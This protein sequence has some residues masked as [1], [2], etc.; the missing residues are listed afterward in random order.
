MKD[1]V[2]FKERVV[3]DEIKYQV[4]ITMYRDTLICKQQK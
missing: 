3:F 4:P 2:V 1:T